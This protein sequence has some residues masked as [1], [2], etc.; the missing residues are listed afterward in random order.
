MKNRNT[1]LVT[2]LS[3]LA[4]F[5][6]SPQL[7]AAC[8]SPDP[9]CPG[10]NL[11]EGFLALGSLTT[12]FYNT[13]IGTYALLSL[14]DGNFSTATG[15]GALFSNTAS[16]NTAVGAGALFN[17]V[18]GSDNNAVG[19]FALFNNVSGSFNNAHGRDALLNSTGDQNNA[20]GDDAMFFNTTGSF[21]TAIGDDALD[22]NVDGS[23]N[24]AIGDEAGSSLGPSVNNCI[25]IGAPGAGPFVTFDN[26]CF[27][28]SI[29]GQAVSDPATQVPVFVDQFNNVGVFNTS[30]RKLKHDIQPMDKA[31]ETL[32]QF[33][34]VTFKYNS[35]WKGTTQ[36][37]LI[38]E[39]VAEVDPQLVVRG[40]DGAIM[41]VH[42]EQISNMLLNEF[43]KEHKKVEAQQATIAELK[44]TVAQQE[45][46]MEVLTAQL[47]EQ[48]AQIQKVS[49][50]LEVN[51]PAPQVVT[52]RP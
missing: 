44:S 18:D 52:S 30:S 20:I 7:R 49:A 14:T 34:P 22:N 6:F 21:N 37:G 25:A 48:A 32:Y 3:A 27:I 24:I 46:G 10:G 19:A 43:L 51:K 50:Q 38:A 16:E 47:K 5:A 33:K 31:S 1:I 41:A 36:Y 45:K 17:N 9:G 8:D 40:R 11:A 28:G 15:A 2:A 29:F 42:Y 39:E 13:G 4:C 23:S 26:T 12:G 35:D